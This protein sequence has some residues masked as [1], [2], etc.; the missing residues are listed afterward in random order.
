MPEGKEYVTRAGLLTGVIN[1]RVDE[2][3]I[4]RSCMM[5]R[6]NEILFHGEVYIPKYG[7]EDF[8]TRCRD[9]VTFYKSGKLK[10]LYLERQQEINSPVGTVKAELVSFYE[11][12][13]LHRV[14]PVYGQINGYWSESEEASL[15]GT[16]KIETGGQMIEAK[17]SCFSFYESGA[18]KS[19]TLWPGE[20]T[21]ILIPSGKIKARLG[22]SFYEDGT[23]KSVEPDKPVPIT[24]QGSSFIAYDNH[25][26]GVHGDTNSLG[27]YVDGTIK[28][29][30]TTISA[31]ILSGGN[32]KIQIEPERRVGLTDIDT[33]DIVPLKLEFQGSNLMI[34]DSDG[35]IH[36]FALEQYQLGTIQIAENLHAEKDC[37]VCSSCRGCGLETIE[38]N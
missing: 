6:R 17:I 36:K 30:K 4:L 19:L 12:G 23:I 5:E 25:P 3:G 33:M 32:D 27:F 7:A 29:L 2:S 1:D 28:T 13:S 38:R 22:I 16:S 31:V 18:V 34:T 20:S 9:A 37:G 11:S 10:S 35:C 26:I 8:R 24:Y 14:F 21:D 15:L